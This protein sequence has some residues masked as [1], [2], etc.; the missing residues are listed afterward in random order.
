[1]FPCG[2][3]WKGK[4]L[5][6]SLEYDKLNAV[7]GPPQSIG[8]FSLLVN[9]EE[10]PLAKVAL[11][12]RFGTLMFGH[13]IKDG[14][15]G[16]I[17]CDAG[18][19]VTL[20]WAQK[21]DGEILA[22]LVEEMRPNLGVGLS[23]CAIGGLVETGQKADDVQISEAM[24][25]VGLYTTKATKMDGVLVTDNRLYWWSAEGQANHPYQLEIPFDQLEQEK[26]TGWWKPKL[27]FIHHKR[28][29]DIVFL[30]MKEAILRSPDPLVLALC[31]RLMV[32]LDQI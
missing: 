13:R 4:K 15:D 26:E 21:P 28:E 31:A 16:W 23:L 29:N 9:G 11:T 24:E 32:Y 30:P 8:V 5:A 14:Y 12:S 17:F 18:G 3:E 6:Y 10:V 27:G 19:G 2:I 20:P 22:G 1:M 25:E 7:I